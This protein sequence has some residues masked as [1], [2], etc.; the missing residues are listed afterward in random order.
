MA[1]I[2]A[3][4]H[5]GPEWERAMRALA[6]IASTARGAMRRRIARRTVNA[7]GKRAAGELQKVMAEKAGAKRPSAV[8]LRRRAAYPSQRDP[9]YTIRQSGQIPIAAIAH[10]FDGR[11]GE[12]GALEFKA[13]S[14]AI[15]RFTRATRLRGRGAKARFL[16]PVRNPLP[17]RLV[18]GIVFSAKRP[19]REVE[20][21][22]DTLPGELEAEYSAQMRSALAAINRR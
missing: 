12:P 9:T 5:R 14:G 16:L 20:R 6:D 7:V 2:K 15:V 8:K 22:A 11:A 1:T 4:I 21:F 3:G 10:D 13:L 18:G 17:E 19:G